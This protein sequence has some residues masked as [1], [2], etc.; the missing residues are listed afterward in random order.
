M[1]KYM[2]LPSLPMVSLLPLAPL[3]CQFGMQIW[4]VSYISSSLIRPSMQSRSL[5][6]LHWSRLD[7]KIKLQESILYKTKRR[8]FRSPTTLKR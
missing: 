4:A 8:C 2:Q 3:T 6:I 1:T 7:L 5:Q